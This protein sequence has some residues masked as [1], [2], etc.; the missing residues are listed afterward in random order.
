MNGAQASIL[1]EELAIDYEM[2]EISFSKN[3]QK[4]DW[5][6]AINPNGR[7]PAMTDHDA[8]DFHVFESGA[9][10][11]YLAEKYGK[12]IGNDAKERS[13]VIQWLMFQMGGIGP[14]QGQANHFNNYA[15]ESIPYGKK[16]YTDETRRLYEVIEK[17]LEGRDYLVG[18]GRGEYS[19]ADMANWSWMIIHRWS[20]IDMSNLPN[21]KAWLER[22]AERPAVQKGV[23]VPMPSSGVSVLEKNKL[24]DEEYEAERKKAS[25]QTTKMFAF[26]KVS[27]EEQEGRKK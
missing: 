8:D 11:I 6:L 25:A 12:F 23:M 3:E 7:I 22:I 21:V 4:A 27:D 16:R 20:Q 14:M 5:F 18:A 10:M 9:M 13:E 26:K 1:L 17:R 19:I 24:S 15:P 2:I